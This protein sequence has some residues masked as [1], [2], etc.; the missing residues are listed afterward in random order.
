[1]SLCALIYHNMKGIGN[2]N[3]LKQIVHIGSQLYSSLSQLSRQSFLLLADFPSMLIVL[4][5]DYQLEYSESYTGNVHGEPIIKGYQYCMGLKRAFESLISEWYRSFILTFGCIAVGISYCADNNPFKVLEM[6]IVKVM[7]EDCVV[8]DISSTDNLV[9]Y[10][11]SLY[12]ATDLYELKGLQVTK[13]DMAISNNVREVL[14]RS[15]GQHKCY[16]DHCFAV[17]LYSLCYLII[18]PRSYWNS[19][20]LDA[21]IEN[22][23]LSLTMQCTVSTV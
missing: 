5:E 8:S 16:K 6:F 17:V 22:Q 2:P 10:F 21:I 18:L 19:N 9:H 4:G 3:E 20:T 11:Q 12:G 15:S 14:K 13:Y 7:F 1:M 23:D